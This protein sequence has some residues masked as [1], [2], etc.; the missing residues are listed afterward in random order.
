MWN[1]IFNKG[2]LHYV[3]VKCLKVVEAIEYDVHGV[4]RTFPDKYLFSFI[5]NNC[6]TLDF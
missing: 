2:I 3:S 4:Y 5:Y 6:N 1:N